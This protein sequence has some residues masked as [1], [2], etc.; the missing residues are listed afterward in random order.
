MPEGPEV[1][2]ASDF[3]NLYF[4]D[5]KIDS[6]EILTDY[7]EKKYG[8]VF[9][10]LNKKIKGKSQS[11]FTIG[12][13][14]FIQ[15]DQNRYFNFHLGMTGGW[16]L[17]LEKHCHFKVTS[18]DKALYYK[19]VRKFGKMRVVD[20]EAIRAK[21]TKEFDSLHF[22]YDIK[23]HFNYLK[24]KVN[25]DS[26][27]CKVLLDQKR[28]P[29]VGNYIK[30][31]ILYAAKTH[32]ERKWGDL[33]D[34]KIKD[35]LVQSQDIMQR[36]YKTGGAELKDFKNPFHTSEFKLKIYGQ[37]FDPEGNKVISQT[38]KDQRRSWWSKVQK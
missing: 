8:E 31:E 30:C 35:I 16:N 14:G 2:I 24:E 27:I 36:S 23:A 10:E 29:G 13:N 28:F 17:D 33:S 3:Y 26:P 4:K 1:K 25:K 38:T 5:C 12:K 20:A 21:H 32:P 18:G 9:D 7:Y 6:F 19:D 15:L 22:D 11:S 37:K 34:K